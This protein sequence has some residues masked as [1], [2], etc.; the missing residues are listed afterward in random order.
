MRRDFGKRLS[1]VFNA[2]LLEKR[3]G[4]VGTRP[5]QKCLFQYGNK[6]V[7]RELDGSC[8]AEKAAGP[9]KAVGLFEAGYFS[10]GFRGCFILGVWPPPQTRVG[11]SGSVRLNK[12]GAWRSGKCN[13]L[14]RWAEYSIMRSAGAQRREPETN[15]RFVGHYA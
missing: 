1:Y 4:L 7:H 15:R 13:R 9:P 11:R 14:L 6:V 2:R 5:S 10:A 12:K 8:K 3:A